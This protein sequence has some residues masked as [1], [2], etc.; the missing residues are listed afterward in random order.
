MIKRLR[1]PGMTGEPLAGV[2]HP[3][4]PADPGSGVR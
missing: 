2:F 3:P 1:F 4:H